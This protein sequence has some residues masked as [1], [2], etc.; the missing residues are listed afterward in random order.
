MSDRRGPRAPEYSISQLHNFEECPRQY[1]YRYVDRIY[2]YEEGIEA[3]LGSRFHESMDKLYA[4][5]ARGRIL[6][7]EEILSYYEKIWAE[8]WHP[9]VV[10]VRADRTADDYRALGRKF[11]ENYY[12]RHHPFEEGEV[13]GLEHYIRFKLDDE[14]R[15]GC[16]GIIDRLM[17]APDGCFEVHDYKTSSKLPEQAE[18]DEDQQLALYQIGVHRLFPEA[19]EVR[20]V[21]HLVAFDVEMRSTRSPEKLKKLKDELGELIDRIEAETEF[22]PHESPLCDWCA[23]WDLCPEKKDKVKG[24]R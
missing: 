16:K 21:W 3:F 13:L 18:L 19:Q 8:K 7:L 20:L 12:K 22:A 2:R 9:E 11:I 4:E 10:L 24:S 23:Y 17:I 1:K 6:T 14:G 15:Y 5:R